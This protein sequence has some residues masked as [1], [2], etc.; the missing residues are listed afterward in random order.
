M[1][2]LHLTTEFPPVIYGGLGTAAGGLVTASSQA[3][4]ETAVLLVGAGGDQAYRRPTSSILETTSESAIRS[5]AGIHVH[6]VSHAD[7]ERYALR[8]ILDCQADVLHL[9]VFWL[10][11]LARSLRDRTGLRIVYTV[12]SL[13]RAEYELGQ[14]PPECLSQWDTQADLISSADLIVALTRSERDLLIE[15]CPR[16]T[17][18]IR[19]IGNGIE[20]TIGAREAVRQRSSNDIPLVLFTGRF[21]ER[22]GIR[23]FLAA[24]ALVLNERPAT[25]FVLAGG[26]RHCDGASMARYWMP[27]ELSACGARVHFTGWLS[28]EELAVWYRRA[29]ILAVSSWYEPFGMVVLEGMLYGLPIL[30]SNIGGPAEILEQGRTALLVPPRN[31]VALAQGLLRLIDDPQLRQQLGLAAA[32][33]V[34]EE[35]SYVRAVQ[36]MKAVYN[37]GRARHRDDVCATI[38]EAAGR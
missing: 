28:A 13:D 15:Y 2:V 36:K 10:W 5:I 16:V 11:P 29:D 19:V 26:H 21:V 6:P 35:W 32:G 18:R 22:K 31:P 33:A 38:S 25:R 1:R 7:A 27:E 24:A 34:R 9:H 37:E 14:G 17:D 4:I 12:H 30:A 23:E 20:D 3:G 8:L